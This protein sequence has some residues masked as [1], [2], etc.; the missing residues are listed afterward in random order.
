MVPVGTRP[1]LG[2]FFTG[3]ESARAVFVAVVS[4]L[5]I[6]EPDFTPSGAGELWITEA[7][8]RNEAVKRK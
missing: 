4:Y 8:K 7:M 3:A 2:R 6:A 5:G 1:Y